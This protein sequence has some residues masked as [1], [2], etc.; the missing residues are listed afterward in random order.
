M[1]NSNFALFC[2]GDD[3]LKEVDPF[4]AELYFNRFSSEVDWDNEKVGIPQA[5]SILEEM[6]SF[7]INIVDENG[8]IWKSVDILR[9]L[10]ED[11]NG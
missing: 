1:N 8:A 6:I 9:M 2:I 4:T 11:L 5:I 10:E 3:P 7:D